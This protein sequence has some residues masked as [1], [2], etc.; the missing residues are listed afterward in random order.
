MVVLK[1]FKPVAP[2]E[3][4][5]GHPLNSKEGNCVIANYRMMYESVDCEHLFAFICVTSTNRIK[6][7]DTHG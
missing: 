1:E 3:W 5:P 4:V 2:S 7:P 6:E